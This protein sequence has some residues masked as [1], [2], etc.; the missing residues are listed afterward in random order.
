MWNYPHREMIKIKFPS[1]SPV[2]IKYINDIIN[3][4]YLLLIQCPAS[5]GLS[6]TWITKQE[7]IINLYSSSQKVAKNLGQSQW[8]Q[9]I[10]ILTSNF[11]V[12]LINS[13]TQEIFTC[14]NISFCLTLI[15]MHS[16]ELSIHS[17]F[18]RRVLKS[19]SLQSNAVI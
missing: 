1:R 15:F 11:L 2:Y 3:T 6:L 12:N 10:A 9:G 16:I 19:L 18:H 4:P 17:V 7:H 13:V 14:F 5:D 8:Q